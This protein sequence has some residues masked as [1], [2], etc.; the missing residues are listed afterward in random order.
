MLIFHSGL[1]TDDLSTD[2]FENNIANQYVLE[3]VGLCPVPVI[4]DINTNHE[5]DYYVTNNYPMVAIGSANLAKIN[6]ADLL[7]YI[8]VFHENR[9]KVHLLGNV[10]YE[11]LAFTPTYSCDSSAWSRHGQN[12]TVLFW[13]PG[14]KAVNKTDLIDFKT[15]SFNR[16]FYYN[17][18]E[19]HL[20]EDYLYNE[21]N[22]KLEDVM[23][24]ENRIN[25]LVANVHHFA[26]IEEKVK[27]H[28]AKLKYGFAD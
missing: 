19:L 15:G 3:E 24:P 11:N 13:N 22:F 17:Y 7:D 25:R 10:S 8:K 23:G 20:L 16:I 28:H 6:F 5:A 2:G 27:E 12:N 9:I 4:H 14:K 1:T 21:L 18:R 26:L